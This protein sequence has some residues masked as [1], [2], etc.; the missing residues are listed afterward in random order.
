MTLSPEGPRSQRLVDEATGQPV[1]LIY[2]LP[3]ELFGGSLSNKDAE[4]VDLCGY[5]KQLWIRRRVIV[6]LT[7]CS[8]IIFSVISLLMPNYYSSSVSAMPPT[9]QQVGGLA[10]FADLANMAGIGVGSGGSAEEVLAILDSRTLRGRLIEEFNLTEYYGEKFLE[11][12]LIEFGSDFS[13]RHDKKT[14]RISF[15]YTHKVPEVSAQVSERAAGLL[16]ERFNEIHQSS[17]RRERVFLEKRLELAEG[18]LA[19]AQQSLAEF[20]RG[21][22]VELEA[23]TRATVEAIGTLQG[24]LIAQQIELRALLASQAARDNPQIVLLQQRVDELSRAISRL[25]GVEGGQGVLLGL[26]AI[27]ALGIDYLNHLRELKRGETLVSMLIAQLEASRIAEV[28][29]ADAVTIVDPAFVPQLKSKPRRG[30]ICVVGTL[31]GFLAVCGWILA[32]PFL[33]RMREG[34]SRSE[35]V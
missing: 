32:S 3:S 25:S 19:R 8:G 12:A 4:V 2:A 24:Q 34:L 5:A 29:D 14:N 1:Q 31:L 20:R 11:D 10:Q 30:L 21:G 15:G 6:S 27:P 26:G 18:E 9:E 22:A 7:V 23:Q 33:G 16:Q 13:V 17:S 28:R 35:A